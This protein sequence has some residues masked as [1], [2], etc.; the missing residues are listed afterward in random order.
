MLLRGHLHVA[1]GKERLQHHPAAGAGP[2]SPVGIHLQ[3]CPCGPARPLH[4]TPPL[5][6]PPTPG[7]SSCP[8]PPSPPLQP[9]SLHRGVAGPLALGR[10]DRGARSGRPVQLWAPGP[11]GGSEG[12]YWHLHRSLHTGQPPC[13]GAGGTAAP[14]PGCLD[15]ECGRGALEMDLGAFF[16]AG[17]GE[18]TCWW[19]CFSRS[20][21]SDS[22][23]PQG[24]QSTRL[25][26]PW[27]APGKNTGVGCHALLQ[28]IFL[29]H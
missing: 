22:C 2:A 27:D 13:R 6:P 26:C 10:E 29:T 4:S 16:R 21:V 5:E 20:V 28:R 8:L 11:P 24:L 9:S 19:W 25:L 15:R 12:R 1:P 17:S 18:K 7:S 14:G 23:D 3:G